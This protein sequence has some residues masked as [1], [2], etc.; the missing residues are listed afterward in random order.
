MNHNHN[1]FTPDFITRLKHAV[2]GLLY[3]SETDAPIHVFAWH[4][5][6]PFSPEAL[7]A[8]V[9]YDRST[10]IQVTDLDSFFRP[11]TTPRDW[12]GPEEQE[13]TARF[14]ALRDLLKNE[15]TDLEVYRV[16]TISIDIYVVGRDSDDHYVGL[17]TNVV[18]T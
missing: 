1:G 4:E 11:V 12:H 2:D 8:H 13:R 10:P 5:G 18:E 14:A 7:L 17:A 3:P 15:L 6:V 16:G 9:G